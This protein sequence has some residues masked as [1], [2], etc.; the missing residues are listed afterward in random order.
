MHAAALRLFSLTL[1]LFFSVTLSYASSYPGSAKWL[2]VRQGDVELFVPEGFEG[3]GIYSMQRAQV[4][5]DSMEVW[6][7]L[8][9][10]ISRILL[11]PWLEIGYDFATVRPMRVELT[12]APAMDKG[13]RP[14]VGLFLDRVTAHEL[15]HT[16]QFSTHEGL[17]KPLRW[18]FG[19]AV[20]PLGVSPD[21][22]VEGQAIWTE[23]ALGGGRLNSS[24]HAQ[25]LRTRIQ[26]GQPWTLSQ[27]AYPGRYSPV[28]NR[29]YIAGAFFYNDLVEQYG[30]EKAGEWMRSRAAWPL[31]MSIPTKRVYGES[32]V[33][34]YDAFLER[35]GQE[36]KTRLSGRSGELSGRML[37]SAPRTDYRR[38]LWETE[39]TLL[40]V[41]D[42]YDRPR[43]L[44]RYHLS[45]GACEEVAKLGYSPHFGFTQ[46]GTGVILSE[47][48]NTSFATEAG[49]VVLVRVDSAGKH[50]DLGIKGWAPSWARTRGE[51]AYVTRDKSGAQALCLVQL[52]EDGMPRGEP[53]SLYI[54]PLGTLGEPVWSPDGSHLAFVADLG[55]GESVYLLWP[56]TGEL[57]KLDIA[58]AANTFDPAFASEG[59]LWVS[60]DPENVLDLFRVNLDSASAERMTA[61]K[62]ASIEPTPGTGG[63]VAYGFSTVEGVVPVIANEHQFLR[64]TTVVR[65]DTLTTL[66]LGVEETSLPGLQDA[67]LHP[68]H[69]WKHIA[70]IFWYPQ[71]IGR[72]EY[73][74][75]AHIYG[76]DPVGLLTW[77]ADAVRGMESGELETNLSAT[78]RGWPMEI[79]ASATRYPA[80]EPSYRDEFSTMLGPTLPIYDGDVWRMREEASLTTWATL[81]NDGNGYYGWW[82]P[83]LGWITRER[84][85]VFPE[86]LYR[87]RY[88]GIRAGVNLARSRSA[89]RDPV[90]HRYFGVGLGV[91]RDLGDLS[92]IEATLAEG[93]ARIHFPGFVNGTVFALTF[94]AQYQDFSWFS[95]SRSAVL[96]RGYDEKDLVSSL[97]DGGRMGMAG[98]EFHFPILYPDAGFGMGA[99][100]FERV[101]GELFAQAASGWGEGRVLMKWLNEDAFGSLGGNV[102]LQGWALYEAEVTLQM[103]AS[104]RTLDRSWR[105]YIGYDL[106]L[107]MISGFT[108]K[109]QSVE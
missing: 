104:W 98:V 78:W 18:I 36:W 19:D 107:D 16:V 95:F 101:T 4:Y 23:S 77:T 94:A 47:F 79:T 108:R 83:Y 2:T 22:S 102:N 75:G 51:L 3:Y 39:R 71:M 34:L 58:D 44:V 109:L 37:E 65:I 8:R 27:I 17:S 99:F 74:Y 61:C 59:M 67:A 86:K 100:H 46:F 15:T 6:Y 96:P 62:T 7:G 91:E 103:G 72:E 93:N 21:W 92:G 9:P 40:M 12:L 33:D 64:Q 52:G 105:F 35:W 26:A 90:A 87:E 49:T 31:T 13:I 68:Y 45:D 73:G 76:R 70:P 80:E 50:H 10:G 32:G 53:R 30:L 55:T 14:Q 88:Q 97:L 20:A 89:D 5:L 42:G 43:R 81:R 63:N 66:Q 24:W 56:D 82:Q 11:N 60:A 1:L 48:R 85:I 41:E 25:F 28:A 106:P 69:F 38:A 29:A 57:L 54:S 84:F